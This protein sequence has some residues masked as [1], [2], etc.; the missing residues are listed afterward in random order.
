MKGRDTQH[1]N[2]WAAVAVQR[3]EQSAAHRH[4]ITP[5]K[6]SPA[7]EDQRQ[8]H[9]L[10]DLYQNTAK[11]GWPILK[12]DPRASLGSVSTE[13]E[14]LMR[15]ETSSM[16]IPQQTLPSE[17]PLPFTDKYGR[18]LE[19]LHYGSNSTIRLN[20]CK[21]S[22][23]DQKR[24]Q[25]LAIK[26]YRY[27]V[28]GSSSLPARA[29]WCSPTAIANLHPRHPNILPITDLL[30]NE[31]SELCLV[32]PYCAGGNLHDLLSREGSLPTGEADCLIAQILRALAFLH[33]HNTAHRDIRLETVLLTQNGAVKLAGFGDE[34]I[35]RLWRECAI[36]TEP[37]E[38]KLDHSPPHSPSSWSLS[39]MLSAFSRSSPP[40]RGSV[41]SASSS[42]SFPG[43]SL[44]YVPPEGFFH[45]SPRHHHGDDGEGSDEDDDDPRPADIWA[46]AVV[47]LALNTG[48]LPWRSARPSRED[49]KYLDY[50]HCR[51]TEDGYPPIEALGHVRFFR[52]NSIESRVFSS[53]D[54]RLV[55][56]RRNAIYAMLNPNPRRRI[57]SK[58]MLR[59]EWMHGVSV[60]DAGEKGL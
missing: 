41:D 29:T 16:A 15:S 30:Y 54:G 13:R 49:T 23:Y 36:P 25:L 34:H 50:L 33:E 6:W 19:I 32:M 40:R 31:R 20:Q 38:E 43:I 12:N 18:C 53:A 26:V 1:H 5:P 22:C 55:Q 35:R 4:F 44:P 59:S 51:R 37:E 48:R 17:S 42:A 27:H 2:A 11:R 45:R 24:K 8:T 57:T 28:L 56:R 47:Y 10:F 7:S 60:C 46:T 14:P 58:N 9:A 52:N 39:W 21:P 3:T